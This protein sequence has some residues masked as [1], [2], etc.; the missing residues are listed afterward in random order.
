MGFVSES[1]AGLG[2]QAVELDYKAPQR[3]T[4]TTHCLF[5][6]VTPEDCALGV[7][8]GQKQTSLCMSDS[9]ASVVWEISNLE[10]GICGLRI[11]VPLST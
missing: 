4:L 2:Q 5:W 11:S 9:L 1:L 8:T 10:S 7:R 3:G 6:A